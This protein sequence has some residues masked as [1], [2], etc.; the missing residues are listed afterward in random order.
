M[1]VYRYW[2]KI[3]RQFGVFHYSEGTPILCL[4]TIIFAFHLQ[5]VALVSTGTV[6]FVVDEN[7]PVGTEVGRIIVD[8][9]HHNSSNTSVVNELSFTLQDTSYFDFDELRSHCLV[10]RGLLDR[11]ADR[12]LCAENGWPEICSWSGVIFVSDGRLLALRVIIRDVND[13]TPSWSTKQ[14]DGMAVLQTTVSENCPL[15]TTVDL[16]LATDPDFGGNSIVRYEM[17]THDIDGGTP[18]FDVLSVNTSNGV[19]YRLVV[20]GLLD[21]EQMPTYILTV[22]AIDGGGNK[23][24]AR[25]TVNVADENDNYPQFVHLKNGTVRLHDDRGFVIYIDEDLPVGNRLPRCPVAVDEDDGEFG[26]LTY[27]FSISTGDIVKRD[28]RIDE[29][30]GEIFVRSKLDYDTG[31]LIQYEF[32]VVAQDHGSPPLLASA[33]VTVNIQDKND[34]PPTITVTSVQQTTDRNNSHGK[35]NLSLLENS[36]AGNLI[37][38]LTVQ[39]LDSG[40]NGI[41]ICKLGETNQ[42]QLTYLRS[43]GKMKILQLISTQPVDRETRPELRVTLRCSDQGMPSQVST[44]LLVVKIIDVNDNPPRFTNQHYSFQT[45]EGNTAEQVIGSI[46][47]YDADFGLNAQITY[48]IEWPQTQEANPFVVNSN[49]ELSARLPL[50][51]ESQPE[52]YHFTVIAHDSGSPQL[53]SYAKVEVALIDVNDCAPNFTHNV[54]HFSIEEELPV[55]TNSTYII[56][57]VRATDCDIGSNA[58]VNYYLDPLSALFKVSNEGYV[59]T[60]SSFNREKQEVFIL[61]L[62]AVDSAQ[63]PQQRL[64]STAE[65][66]VTVTDIND[67]GPVFVRP[68][69]ENGTNE[70]LLSVHEKPESLVTRV[71][72]TDEDDGQNGFIRYLLVGEKRTFNLHSDNGELILLRMLSVEDLGDYTLTVLAVDNGEKPKTATAQIEVRIADIPPK[73]TSQSIEGGETT[74]LSPNVPEKKANELIILCIILITIF[75]SSIL[76]GIIFV[77]S[78]GGFSALL[79][80]HKVIHQDYR[81]THSPKEQC[82]SKDVNLTQTFEQ[83]LQTCYPQETTRNGYFKTGTHPFIQCDEEIQYGVQYNQQ[84]SDQCIREWPIPQHGNTSAHRPGYFGEFAMEENELAQLQHPFILKTGTYFE[85]FHVPDQNYYQEKLYDLCNKVSTSTEDYC[86]LLKTPVYPLTMTGVS[87]SE[88]KAKQILTAQSSMLMSSPYRT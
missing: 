57:H 53:S 56:G 21:R 87:T 74:R 85:N 19:T 16:P 54:Y 27:S 35:S 80:K 55:T 82:S 23:G 46:T 39:D 76:I 62:S 5:S 75:I 84:Y 32:L 7:S 66:H 40:K 20:N 83:D 77:V 58:Q 65:I 38:T 26:R 25:L 69:F 88:A 78:K 79:F 14:K 72:A 31:G 6:T 64:S 24:L 34:N 30:T 37:A 49:G 10:V 1:S 52:G 41:F 47:A 68:P 22:A 4:S 61:K 67:N 63:D 2:F 60:T 3:I 70:I 86:G 51:R 18:P 13:N 42:L 17:V 29:H 33:R 11:D 73:E 50:D 12:Q 81:Q 15:G 28:F 48:F 36:L 8:E 59:Y 9:K 45:S 43:M 44:E 71:E